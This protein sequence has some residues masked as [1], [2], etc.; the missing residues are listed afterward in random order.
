MSR[1]V[2]AAVIGFLPIAS[3]L[4]LNVA[5]AA[6]RPVSKVVDLLGGMK[7][8]VE[9]E[10]RQDEK[11][12]RDYK[13]WCKTNGDEKAKAIAEAREK[14][15]VYKQRV[16]LLAGKSKVRKKQ[17]EEA[18]DEVAKNQASLDTATALRK[19]QETE[20]VKSKQDIEKNLGAI[21]NA[22]VTLGANLFLQS[23]AKRQ[24]LTDQI[25]K[26]MDN[27]NHVKTED[28][29]AVM[30]FLQG[31]ITGQG[32]ADSVTGVLNGMLD[33]FK[34][35]LVELKDEEA[36]HKKAY[37]DTRLAKEDEIATG[38]ALVQKKKAE[39]AEYDKERAEKQQA[40]KDMEKVL[41]E[42]VEFA[43][44]VIEKCKIMDK[45]YDERT[46]TRAEEVK[47]IEK[48]IGVLDSDE[49][50]SSFGKSLSFIQ[51]SSLTNTAVEAK[52]LASAADEL[53]KVGNKGNTRLLALAMRAKIDSFTKVKAAI[54]EMV[55]ELKAQRQEEVEKRD[56]CID[57]MNK[58]KAKTAEEDEK[59]SDLKLK[60]ENIEKKID[61]VKSE[62]EELQVQV[63][64]EQSQQEK[65]TKNREE[66]AITFKE[67]VEEQ[68]QT[69]VLL[70]KAQEV[71]KGFYGG[72]SSLAQV[73]LHG[74]GPD[75][76]KTEPETFSS[77]KN[78]KQSFSVLSQIQQIM[79]DAKALQR[80][81][82][83]A[84]KDA[85]D[86]YQTF[87]DKTQASIA[88]KNKAISDKTRLKAQQE[89]ELVQTKNDLES[90]NGDL[91]TLANTKRELDNDC[92]FLLN[93]FKMRQ[94][95]FQEEMDSL[96]TAKAIL[97]GAKDESVLN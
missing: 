41:A 62:I 38:N 8:Q 30:S 39:K 68:K 12:F 32:P 42:D 36:G 13:C 83:R 44:K 51:D 37:D 10:G 92:N 5:E 75:P 15:P 7:K 81:A 53:V 14:L 45:E 23:N 3:G 34:S 71:L 6:G 1:A 46:K 2:K 26:I 78:N 60:I 31:E 55:V 58:N 16:E 57:A 79:A 84:E 85:K 54:D 73:R 97:S 56:F 87:S 90:T 11:Q 50:H 61:E 64:D 69:Q 27:S 25:K 72:G 48:A 94:T 40:I 89:Q 20:F 93:N 67:T 65:A 77:Y 52:R 35:D 86:S 21:K 19:E 24:E 47:T 63:K 49:A 70:A 17:Y 4:E 91:D 9:R 59:K 66:E 43:A 28:R 82:E 33:D 80:E 74:D 76:M 29:F 96:A 95:A 22:K 18:E 88:G